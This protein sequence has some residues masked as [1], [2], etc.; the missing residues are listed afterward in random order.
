M[1]QGTM[2]GAYAQSMKDAANNSN[3]AMNGFVGMGVANMASGE[4]M[5][6]ATTSPWQN[7]TPAQSS[8]NNGTDS[9]ESWECPDCGTKL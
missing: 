3:G 6:G 4:M 7:A 2:V 9:A 5:A 1:Q 8:S